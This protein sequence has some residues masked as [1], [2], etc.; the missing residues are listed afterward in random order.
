MKIS[1]FEICALR[2]GKIM[3][4]CLYIKNRKKAM[5]IPVGD[6]IAGT[7]NFTERLNIIYEF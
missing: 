7:G 1:L 6:D 3:E 5:P 2:C 4:Y